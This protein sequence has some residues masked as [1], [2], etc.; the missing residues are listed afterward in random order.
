[1][2]KSKILIVEDEPGIAESLENSI[3]E[4]GYETASIVAT[5]EDAI[6]AVKSGN[7]DLVLMDIIL[8]SEMMGT[9]AANYIWSKFQIPIIFLTGFVNS[10]FI[11]SAK[12]SQ[13]FGYILKP[14]EEKELFALI[15][16]ALNKSQMERRSFRINS[17]LK[18]ARKINQIINRENDLN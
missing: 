12:L 11:D 18:I 10:S 13:P 4:L 14:Y 5:G 16:I 9:E 15:E 2:G 6:N 1:M 8:S 7:V 3:E 17:L